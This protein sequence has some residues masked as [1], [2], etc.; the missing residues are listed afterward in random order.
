MYF[1]LKMLLLT[2]QAFSNLNIA[3]HLNIEL[4]YFEGNLTMTSPLFA[5][6]HCDKDK[7]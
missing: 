6:E 7:K 2:V 4:M 5:D 1:V 3:L